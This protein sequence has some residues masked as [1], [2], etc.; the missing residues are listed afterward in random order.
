[1]HLVVPML[2]TGL[3]IWLALL[4]AIVIGRILK[5]D[6]NTAGLLRHGRSD[7]NVAPERVLLTAGFPA[8]ILSY[9]FLGLHVDVHTL[10]PALPDVPDSLLMLLTGSNGLYLAGKIARSAK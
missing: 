1:M 7:P 4:F 2:K 3:L 5:G 10:H 6:L 8:V 9:V